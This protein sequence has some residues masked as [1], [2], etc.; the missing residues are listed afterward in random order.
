M[1]RTLICQCT[2]FGVVRP[3]L[4]DGFSECTHSRIS[5]C[6]L[7]VDAVYPVRSWPGLGHSGEA[8]PLSFQHH[9]LWGSTQFHLCHLDLVVLT[10][11]LPRSSSF[12]G[13]TRWWN[14]VPTTSGLSS[15]A[16]LVLWGGASWQSFRM[17]FYQLSLK[18]GFRTS[19]CRSE[20]YQAQQRASPGQC[21]D[22]C[23]MLS[24]EV[25]M[26]MHQAV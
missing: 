14:H 22:S 18:R 9:P 3:S 26:Q 17:A 25:W 21:S 15:A 4:D 8:P 16:W 10:G 7:K 5:G 11:C 12:L 23:F 24:W 6:G 13:D 1:I 2:L 19:M 20:W